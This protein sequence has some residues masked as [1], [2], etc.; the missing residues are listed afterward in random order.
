MGVDRRPPGLLATALAVLVLVTAGGWQAARRTEHVTVTT[1]RADARQ[2]GVLALAAP[3]ID[4]ALLLAVQGVRLDNTPRSRAVLLAVLSRS[5]QLIGV[6]HVPPGEVGP[7]QDSIVA[8]RG[9]LRASVT[10]DRTV[11]L[12]D[13][14]SGRRTDQLHGHTAPVRRLAFSADDATLRTTDASGTVLTWD[15]RG[16]RRFAPRIVT[17]D[18]GLGGRTAMIP[19]PDGRAVVAVGAAADG[20]MRILHLTGGFAGPP[21]G[22]RRGGRSGPV[23]RPDGARLATISGDGFLRTWDPVTGAQIAGHHSVAGVGAAITYDPDGWTI[24]MASR[25]GRLYRMDAERLTRIGSAVPIGHRLAAVAA[26]PGGRLAA[27][28]GA[29]TGSDDA[30]LT[31]YAVVDLVT[32]GV[33]RRGALAFDGTALAFAPD[34]RRLAIAGQ[35]GELLLVDVRSGRPVRPPVIGHNGSVLSVAYS[36]DGTRIVTG[37]YDGRVGL[38]NARTG[39]MLGSMLPGARG[40]GTRPTFLPDG[41][42]VLISAEDGTVSRWDARP[43]RWLAFACAVA[44]RDLSPDEWRRALGDRPYRPTC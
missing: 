6:A 29:V 14:A 16:D 42:A 10:A 18:R 7:A 5:P 27:T 12:W 21:F 38:W 9:H 26:A 43:A 2:L 4:R 32:G 40:T 41:H 11:A 23:W 20:G 24:L 34:G 13:I 28:L 25:D 33:T 37:G 44:G 8:N 1:A 35:M 15:L 39:E 22:S 30:R 31:R 3:E 36:A 19:G 17:D